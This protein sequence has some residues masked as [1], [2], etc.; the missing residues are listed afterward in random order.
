MR[1]EA[2]QQVVQRCVS[3]LETCLT[4]SGTRD[5]RATGLAE[6]EDELCQVAD[7]LVRQLL[8]TL[9]RRQ[10]TQVAEGA[11]C[12]PRCGGALDEKPDRTTP[13][14]TRRGRVSWKQPVRRCKTCRRDFFPSGESPRL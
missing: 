11:E 5:L 6:M 10:A 13:L 9:L 12:C 14:E 1:Q 7:E 3:E 4:E 2:L 8:P